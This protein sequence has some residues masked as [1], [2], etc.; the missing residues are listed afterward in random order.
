MS[1]C[2]IYKH[3]DINLLDYHLFYESDYI[4]VLLH[5]GHM[6]QDT[7]SGFALAH[8]WLVA[9]HLKEPPLAAAQLWSPPS[10]P[11]WGPQAAAHVQVGAHRC[12]NL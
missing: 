12:T 7:P 10:P 8:T 9:A 6:W 1:H 2:T 11:T 5:Q 4:G 3:C